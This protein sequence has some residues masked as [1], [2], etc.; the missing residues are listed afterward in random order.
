MPT[1]V[2]KSRGVDLEAETAALDQILKQVASYTKDASMP[3]MWHTLA[4][5]FAA[6]M[7]IATKKDFPSFLAQQLAFLRRR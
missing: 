3:L 2:K 5:L 4:S 7:K 1:A 6:Y